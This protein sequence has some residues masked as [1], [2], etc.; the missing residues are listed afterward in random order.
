MLFIYAILHSF[1]S[2]VE[3]TVYGTY[4]AF[5][6][7][8]MNFI[9]ANELSISFNAI[10][11]CNNIQ[12][13]QRMNIWTFGHSDITNIFSILHNGWSLTQIENQS[14]CMTN[15][16][17]LELYNNTICIKNQWVASFIQNGQS[18]MWTDK[19]WCSNNNHL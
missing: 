15:N 11:T 7:T 8:S 10:S 13:H 2:T 9:N 12:Q 18:L 3:T 14:H 5:I 1:M 6:S 19:H 16:G 17:V 4:T